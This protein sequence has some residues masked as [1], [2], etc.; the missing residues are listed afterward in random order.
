MGGFPTGAESRLES[1]TD[2]LPFARITF[3]KKLESEL[4]K[5][6]AASSALRRKEA[7]GL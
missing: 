4:C 1:C 5:A 6:F 3:A 2:I 7:F